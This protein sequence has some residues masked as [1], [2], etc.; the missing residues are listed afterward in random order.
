MLI[1]FIQFFAQL[2]IALAILRVAQVKLLDR[3]PDSALGAAI[4]FLN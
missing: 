2:V 1:D 4:A 3:N